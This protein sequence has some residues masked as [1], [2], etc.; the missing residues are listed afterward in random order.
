MYSGSNLS[1]SVNNRFQNVR[2][3]ASTLYK[4]DNTVD[5]EDDGM[6]DDV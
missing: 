4:Q 2:P 1:K 3:G 5:I 6:F